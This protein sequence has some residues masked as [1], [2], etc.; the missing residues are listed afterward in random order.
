MTYLSASSDTAGVVQ[1]GMSATASNVADIAG[2]I[3]AVKQ[4][5]EAVRA[6]KNEYEAAIARSKLAVL[7][8]QLA[9]AKAI[10]FQRN[11]KWYILAGAA[12]L[13]VLLIAARI[14][15]GRRK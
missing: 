13:G 9:T 7:E 3:T 2:L 5:R 11:M 14:S 10:E 8:Q 1:Y 15:S 6:A 4:G 12:G